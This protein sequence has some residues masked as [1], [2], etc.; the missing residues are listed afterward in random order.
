MILFKV[1]FS[2]Q[3]LYHPMEAALLLRGLGRVYYKV[4][5]LGTFVS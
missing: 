2:F 1:G 5:N 4:T 3:L